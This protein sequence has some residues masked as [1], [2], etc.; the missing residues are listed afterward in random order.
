[1]L[2]PMSSS[3][4]SRITITHPQD[5]KALAH[6][7]RQQVLTELYAGEILTAS[8]AAQVCGLSPSAMSYHLRALHRVG[9][10]V[11]DD[12]TDGRE[13]PWRAAADTFEI[14][15][16]AYAAAGLDASRE[17]L[18]AWSAGLLVG[19]DR[20]VERISAGHDDGLASAGQLW[21]TPDE[22]HELGHEVLAI[23]R[24][25]SGRTRADHPDTAALRQVYLLSLPVASNEPSSPK[26][27]RS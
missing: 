15:H 2:L 23:W 16:S 22:E 10:V 11:R 27:Q 21:L 3:P 9:L 25:F 13:R 14:A 1:M 17:H 5:L 4:L 12:S 26:P 20:L 8:E 6:P 24:R 19:M 7:A 18:Q